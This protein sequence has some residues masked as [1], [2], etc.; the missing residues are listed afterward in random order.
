MRTKPDKSRIEQVLALLQETGGIS[1]LTMKLMG[2]CPS[3]QTLWLNRLQ[4]QELVTKRDTSMG[5]AY[6]MTAQGSRYLKQLNA[7][8]HRDDS[9][10]TGL[11]TEMIERSASI[12]EVVA[13]LKLSGYSTHQDDKPAIYD[14]IMKVR[15]LEAA[16][17]P[18]ELEAYLSSPRNQESYQYTFRSCRDRK[19]YE[20]RS[21]PMNCFYTSKEV[22]SY[23]SG[24][25]KEQFRMFSEQSAVSFSRITGLLITPSSSYRLYNTRKAAMKV[26]MGGENAMKIALADVVSCLSTAKELQVENVIIFGDGF[27][28][29][30]KLMEASRKAALRIPGKK[31][32]EAP[33]PA[34][35]MR[36]NTIGKKVL[37]IPLDPVSVPLLQIM[38]FP[39]WQEFLR[40]MAFGSDYQASTDHHSV[41]DGYLRGVPVY[42][43]FIPDLRRLENLM[44]YLQYVDVERVVIACLDWQKPFYDTVLETVE[45]KS[46]VRFYCFQ[47][48]NLLAAV[49]VLSKYYFDGGDRHV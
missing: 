14:A 34:S 35:V 42:L 40:K 37:Y 21:T 11:N 39:G 24:K 44:H 5:K 10:V 47:Q 17:L 43:E 18:N 33:N 2:I 28:G 8:R 22:K 15:T 29:A 20:R 36:I 45:I 19:Q 23:I 31:R 26:R 13:L 6:I 27:K 7:R 30:E 46:E 41:F 4:E 16:V 38:Q 49:E 3:K 32:D 1:R 48:E 9:A 12:S 25:M